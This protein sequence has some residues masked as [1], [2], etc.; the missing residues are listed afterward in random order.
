MDIPQLPT[1]LELITGQR[2]GSPDSD[3]TRRR[4]ACPS[5]ADPKPEAIVSADDRCG[6]DAA[7]GSAGV[8]LL[9]HT[10]GVVTWAWRSVF[11]HLDGVAQRPGHD[12][13]ESGVVA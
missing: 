10:P 7:T 3:E 12:A 2:A 6:I 13:R 4:S 9:L 11:R 1:M 8:A 5:S